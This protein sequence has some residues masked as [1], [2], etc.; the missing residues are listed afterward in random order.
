[1]IKEDR[2]STVEGFWKGKRRAPSVYSRLV[3]FRSPASFFSNLHLQIES[4]N[5]NMDPLSPAVIVNAELL[6]F[7]VGRRVRTVMQVVRSDVLAVIGKS[8]DEKQLIVKGSP[9]APLTS[10]VEVIG[11]VN[12]DKSIKAELWTNFGDEIDMLS[13]HKLCQLANGEFKHLFL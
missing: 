6:P 11:I 7:Y 3:C 5:Q 10:F 9:P 12:S 4:I 13:Y 8:P 2:R 1:M